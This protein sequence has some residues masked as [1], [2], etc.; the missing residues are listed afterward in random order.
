MQSTAPDSP[1][2]APR[3]SPQFFADTAGSEAATQSLTPLRS[4]PSPA[5]AQMAP[6]QRSWMLPHAAAELAPT[7]HLLS[8]AKE[9]KLMA[10]YGS[11]A[12]VIIGERS[13]CGVLGEAL[14]AQN[15]E[16]ERAWRALRELGDAAR[17]ALFSDLWFR[18]LKPLVPAADYQ[19]AANFVHALF[20]ETRGVAL[21]VDVA[22]SLHGLSIEECLAWCARAPAATHRAPTA[23][24]RHPPLPTPNVLAWR[25]GTCMARWAPTS[26]TRRGSSS[27]R[28][29]SPAGTW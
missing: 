12:F 1:P 11:C 8:L 5:A 22:R 13:A 7:A 3:P 15:E 23:T 21:L 2:S 28:W 20:F 10:A 19:A 25:A 6:A 9:K 18:K 17:T 29:N 27:A 24:R 4:S 26:S 16:V 14:G